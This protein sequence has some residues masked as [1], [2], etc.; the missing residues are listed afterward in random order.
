MHVEKLP[1]NARELALD[2]LRRQ[3]YPDTD[4][5]RTFD[6]RGHRFVFE[7]DAVSEPSLDDETQATFTKF[8]NRVTYTA[9]WVLG[10]TLTA[11]FIAIVVTVLKN[12]NK[13]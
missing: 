1:N 7:Q 11:G 2:K 4:F 9:F 13:I 6:W 5:A 8:V 3:Q 10:I 12:S